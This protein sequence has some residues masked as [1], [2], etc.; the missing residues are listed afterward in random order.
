MMPL[1]SGYIQRSKEA[2][3]NEGHRS[4]WRLRQNYLLDLLNLRLG[5]VRD[6]ELEFGQSTPANASADMAN[7]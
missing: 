6:S 3:P 4:P 7:R 1:S 2:L 5:R